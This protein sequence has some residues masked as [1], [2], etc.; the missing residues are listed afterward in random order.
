M[1][2]WKAP[3]QGLSLWRFWK[4]GKQHPIQQRARCRGPAFWVLG[5]LATRDCQGK[6]SA[7]VIWWSGFLLIVMSF[8]SGGT[9]H[10][11]LLRNRDRQRRVRWKRAAGGKE[12]Q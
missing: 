10:A 5:F 1:A 3:G 4:N 7:T 11:G 2:A 12:L 6:G 9:V 8:S